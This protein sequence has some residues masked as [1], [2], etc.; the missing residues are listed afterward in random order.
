M[1]INTTATT[2][3][4]PHY[5][6]NQSSY[7]YGDELKHWSNTPISYSVDIA[8][9]NHFSELLNFPLDR[10]IYAS[11]EYCFR[12]RSEKNN[13]NLN[14]PFLNYYRK[15]YDDSDKLWFNDYSNRF[16]IIDYENKFT[17]KLGGKLKVYPINIEYEG[18]VFFSQNKDCEYATNKLLYDSSNETIITPEL[19]TSNGDILLNAGV[20]NLN[21]DY[22]PNFQ[23]TDWL[24][25]NHMFSI[26]L[27]FSVRTF[28]IGDFDTNPTHAHIDGNPLGLKVA[29]SIMLTFISAKKLNHD[30]L[31][32]SKKMETLISEYFET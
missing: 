18:T 32:E 16:G 13:G 12:K 5:I 4:N 20:L 10:I 8:L 22:M 2:N 30:N 11:N 27:D 3:P 28:M 9:E 1:N 19:E 6:T 31:L 25:Q 21:V 14:L 23:E 17:S 24:E 29:K 7:Y 26:G 15:T